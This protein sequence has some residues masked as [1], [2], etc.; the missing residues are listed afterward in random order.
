LV[1]GW[2]P[3]IAGARRYSVTTVSPGSALCWTLELIARLKFQNC[4]ANW[5]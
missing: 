3:G 1:G 4:Q 5:R 2:K